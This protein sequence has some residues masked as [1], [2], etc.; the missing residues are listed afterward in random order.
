M[1]FQDAFAKLCQTLTETGYDFLRDNL[2]DELE[3]LKTDPTRGERLRF[4]KSCGV[5]ALLLSD[6]C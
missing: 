6:T 1:G 2:V 3:K 4:L 5:L